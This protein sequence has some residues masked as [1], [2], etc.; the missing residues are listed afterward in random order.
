M[1]DD[2]ELAIYIYLWLAWTD[3]YTINKTW[4]V[5]IPHPGTWQRIHTVVSKRCPRWNPRCNAESERLNISESS[6]KISSN[7]LVS[8]DEKKY[9]WAA[10]IKYT[11][12]LEADE[13]LLRCNTQDSKS[14]CVK[15]VDTVLYC[16][17]LYEDSYWTQYTSGR[18]KIFANLRRKK[19]LWSLHLLTWGHLLRPGK[20]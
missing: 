9:D 4:N 5:N 3:L 8:R 15:Q 19:S 17:V 10:S 18:R 6:I 14:D 2:G 12:F 1:Q 11:V 13:A 20:N 16:T 7:K